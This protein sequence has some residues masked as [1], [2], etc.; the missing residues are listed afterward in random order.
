MRIVAP[1]LA[2][3]L[4]G[5]KPHLAAEVSNR[6][7]SAAGENL[8]MR[9]WPFIAAGVLLVLLGAIVTTDLLKA[10]GPMRRSLESADELSRRVAELEVLA[11]RLFALVLGAGALGLGV[12][13]SRVCRSHWVGSIWAHP[14][15]S[16]PAFDAKTIMTMPFVLLASGVVGFLALMNFGPGLIG[17]EQ[18]IIWSLEDGLGQ[19]LTAYVFIL[20]GVVALV[21]A[22]HEKS[23]QRK[24]WTRLLGIGFLLP[25]PT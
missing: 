15:E 8:K 20:A 25:D 7:P 6:R 12:F 9:P 17:E 14:A 11:F 3:N 5:G 22:H 19:Q 23:K 16:A 21:A 18:V 4:I 13:W 2:T 1:P 24:F 10:L